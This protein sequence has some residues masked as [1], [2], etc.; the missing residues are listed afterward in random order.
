[1]YDEGKLHRHG[2]N[3]YIQIW[4]FCLRVAVKRTETKGKTTSQAKWEDS[5]RKAFKVNYQLEK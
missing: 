4:L 3:H 5:L 2:R 1:M